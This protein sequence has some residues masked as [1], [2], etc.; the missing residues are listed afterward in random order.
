M[1]LEKRDALL[2]TVDELKQQIVARQ[3]CSIADAAE[4]AYLR[5]EAARA[6]GVAEEHERTLAEIDG[7]LERI[8]SG[9]Y[10]VC[11]VSGEPIGF[12]RLQLVPWTRVSAD[13]GVG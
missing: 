9:Q 4:A 13:A 10:G 5:E 11:E 7:A 8:R 3:D 12:A 1:L 6:Q 2:S